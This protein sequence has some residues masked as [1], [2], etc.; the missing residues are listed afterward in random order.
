MPL[1]S[2][3]GPNSKSDSFLVVGFLNNFGRHISNTATELNVVIV[4]SSARSSLTLGDY[5][6]LLPAAAGFI[7]LFSIFRWGQGGAGGSQNFG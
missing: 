3:W 5:A 6:S 4:V 7:L 1:L 2:S